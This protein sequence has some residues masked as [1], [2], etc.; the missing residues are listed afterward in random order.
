MIKNQ[1]TALILDL[2]DFR[3]KTTGTSKPLGFSKTPILVNGIDDAVAN[4]V[5]E[6]CSNIPYG[7]AEGSIKATGVGLDTQI[8]AGAVYSNW[9]PE[10]GTMEMYFASDSSKWATRR[11]IHGLLAHP[12]IECECQ[13]ITVCIPENNRDALNLATG[14]GFEPEARL[15]RAYGLDESAII[16]R[17][18]RE[19]WEK[20]KFGLRDED[21]PRGPRSDGRAD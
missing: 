14:V 4:W 12:F 6:R 21:M 5:A 19:D 11:I 10:F 15:D 16:L 13:R 2:N 9:Q 8:I 7:W 17:L 18:F 3:S 1:S 20:G